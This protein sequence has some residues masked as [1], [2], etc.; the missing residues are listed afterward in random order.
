M[1]RLKQQKAN[2]M[3]HSSSGPPQELGTQSSW[4]A[5]SG[6]EPSVLNEESTD[7][8]QEA[9]EAAPSHNTEEREGLLKADA[10]V[11]HRQSISSTSSRLSANKVPRV[12]AYEKSVKCRFIR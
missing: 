4:T 3:S 11:S 1:L 10:I 8:A 2:L 9:C 6:D 5:I 7:S 12:V